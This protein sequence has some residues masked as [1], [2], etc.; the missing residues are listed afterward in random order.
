MN[1]TATAATKEIPVEVKLIPL[2]KI[3][4]S[5]TNPRKHLGDLDGLTATIK[6]HGVRQP[7]SVRRK[8]KTQFE[9]VYGHRRHAAA[10][11]AGLE[12]L[13]ATIC[14][15]TDD[16]VLEL[17]II[18]NSQRE[19]VHPLDEADG[20]KLLAKR[21]QSAAE[22]SERVGRSPKHVAERLR[23]A[24]LVPAAR[25]AL[26]KEQMTLGAAVELAKLPTAHLQNKAFD[27][28]KKRFWF[29]MGQIENG[30][31]R[32]AHVEQ[33]IQENYLLRLRGVPWKLDD[34]E[35]APKRGACNV[36][37][38]RTSAQAE[39]FDS[40]SKTDLCL[41]Q[42]C[43]R[44]KSDAAFQ[45]MKADSDGVFIDGKAA[46]Q[47]LTYDGGF[48]NLT[49]SKWIDGKDVKIST[50]VKKAKV[51]TAKIQ[52]PTTKQIINAVSDEDL[53]KALKAYSPEAADRRTTTS[54]E[55]KAERAKENEKRRQQK[56]VVDRVLAEASEAFNT[57]DLNFSEVLC[58]FVVDRMDS[59]IQ[60]Q[61]VKRRELEPVREKVW[62]GS[63]KTQL[64][65][66]RT[67]RKAYDEADEAGKQNLIFELLL[68]HSAPREYF[69]AQPLWTAAT[70]MLG[71]DIK[72]ITKE[73]A[74]ERR[75]KTKP[76]PKKKAAK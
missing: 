32:K 22:I 53:N 23:L 45:R 14:D 12:L 24:D 65:V 3:R 19:D 63:D 42:E 37:P 11:K 74:A 15:L 25:K 49:D 31:L 1:T 68:A 9:L 46:K 55:R 29:Q 70:E 30:G 44:A 62:A 18:E 72:A 50:I 39:L 35:L 54:A 60:R 52:D 58:E 36:C 27:E 10:K 26:D 64:N 51:P 41:D 61:V 56:M 33:F 28:L 6:K 48:T 21:G 43:F 71:V 73:V 38:K 13:P 16:E 20:Y 2:S 8:G 34:A 59:D 57:D 4:P 40:A 75:Q 17:Q 76:K 66:R 47:A 69:K 5:P 7:V 67:I